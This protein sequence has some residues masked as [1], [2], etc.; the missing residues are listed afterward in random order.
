MQDISEKFFSYLAETSI[1][2]LIAIIIS[3]AI[4]SFFTNKDISFEYLKK[5]ISSSIAIIFIISNLIYYKDDL[6][7]KYDEKIFNINIEL[8]KLVNEK[9]RKILNDELEKYKH[10]NSNSEV[11][12]KAEVTLKAILAITIYFLWFHF[13]I[14]IYGKYTSKKEKIAYLSLYIS[15]FALIRYLYYH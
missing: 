12:Y 10:K 6:N 3:I 14:D 8:I 2:T 5:I 4:V 13:L 7:S 15:I 1:E 9:E 11:F